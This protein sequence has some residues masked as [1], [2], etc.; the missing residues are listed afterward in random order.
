M[1]T[2]SRI[3]RKL[4]RYPYG[5]LDIIDEWSPSQLDHVVENLLIRAIFGVLFRFLWIELLIPCW[6]KNS[7]EVL[8]LSP[9]L[10][11]GLNQKRRDPILKGFSTRRKKDIS[12]CA[13]NE[14]TLL[15]NY[16]MIL[17]ATKLRNLPSQGS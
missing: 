6:K 8:D 11:N 4:A 10:S 16:L 12:R 1:Y 14:R 3:K 17:R 5:T 2:K 13:M 7:Q 15:R 9:L